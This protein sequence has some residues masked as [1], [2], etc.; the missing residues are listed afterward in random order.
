MLHTYHLYT[1]VLDFCPG[2]KCFVFADTFTQ[3]ALKEGPQCDLERAVSFPQA[4]DPAHHPSS[5]QHTRMKQRKKADC[6]P[7]GHTCSPGEAF[8]KRAT[9]LL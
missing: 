7:G 4:Q 6:G 1:L 5:H 3:P 9:G 2:F 8:P